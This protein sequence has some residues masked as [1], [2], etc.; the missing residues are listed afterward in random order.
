[1]SI[2]N[3]IDRL[4]AARAKLKREGFTD[5]LARDMDDMLLEV[6]NSRSGCGI[7]HASTPATDLFQRQAE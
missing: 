2:A 5:D 7:K 3:L 1:M 6:R 4:A